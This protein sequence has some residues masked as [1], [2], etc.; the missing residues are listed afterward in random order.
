MNHLKRN[1]VGYLPHMLFSL[2]ISY[3]GFKLVFFG[4]LHAIF[5]F[6]FDDKST[7]TIRQLNKMIELEVHNKNS[8]KIKEIIKESL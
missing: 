7:R 8:R 4:V 1:S 6:L 2:R 5:P 3:Y